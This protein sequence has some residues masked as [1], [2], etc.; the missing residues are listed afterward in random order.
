M[1]LSVLDTYRLTYVAYRLAVAVDW[2][3]IKD[4]HLMYNGGK[5]ESATSGAVDRN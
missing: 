3:V 4:F 1:F 2:E 5:V